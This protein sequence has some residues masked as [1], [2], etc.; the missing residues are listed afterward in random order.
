MPQRPVSDFFPWLFATPPRLAGA[1]VALLGLLLLVCVGPLRRQ[2]QTHSD[3]QAVGRAGFQ[4]CVIDVPMRSHIHVFRREGDTV[5][6]A[7]I[8]TEAVGYARFVTHPDRS[9]KPL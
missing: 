3:S 5:V 9:E 8:A 2:V 1:G 4:T 7:L 6:D